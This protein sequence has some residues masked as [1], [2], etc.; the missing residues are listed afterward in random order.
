MHPRHLFLSI[1]DLDRVGGPGLC[2]AVPSRSG[3]VQGP[4]SLYT[5]S[6]CPPPKPL[7]LP[8]ARATSKED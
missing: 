5:P 7:C 6:P 2:P 3:P 4:A 8:L 1:S